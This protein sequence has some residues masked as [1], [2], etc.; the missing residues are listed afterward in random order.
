MVSAVSLAAVSVSWATQAA[1]PPVTGSAISTGIS[2]LSDGSSIVTGYFFGTATFG[3]TTLTATSATSDLFVAKLDAAG[4]YAWATSV[5]GFSLDQGYAISTLSD[6]SSIVTG[7]FYETVAFGS[8][9]PITSTGNQDVFVAKLDASGNWLWATKAGGS[10]DEQGRAVSTLSDGSSIV[11]GYFYGTAAFGSTSLESAGD[12]D[13]FVAKIDASGNWLWATKAG[14][15]PADV[16]RGISTISDG[17]AIVTGKIEGDATFGSTTL[18]NAGG[19]D[20]FVAKIDASGNWLWATK[21]GGSSGEEGNAISTLSDG[22]S[23][24]TGYFYGTATFG[25]ITL[26]SADSADLFVTKIDPSGN[27]VWAT[28]AGNTYFD[29]STA[30]STL[31]DGSAIVT[32]LFIG[33]STFGATTFEV[34]GNNEF[35]QDIFVAR[36]DAGG[37]WKWAR[38]EGGTSLD[39]GSAVSTLSDGSA[40]VTGNFRG[41]AIIG[42]ITLEYPDSGAWNV[43]VAKFTPLDSDNDGVSDEQEEINGTDPTKADTDDDGENDGAEGT[44]DSDNDGT[45]DALESSVTD[46]DNDGVPDEQDSNNTSGDNDTDGDGVSNADEV[47]AGTDPMDSD[48]IPVTT[49]PTFALLLLSLLLSLFGYRRMAH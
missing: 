11:T 4:N 5:G 37:D 47:A 26:T 9:P 19:P 6:G 25:S 17:S 35:A 48:S 28:R 46:T 10:L 14:G 21:A 42:D 22:S 12:A 43:V 1:A 33:T 7:Y 29:V 18:T 31:S 49:L 8:T 39:E 34:A 20:V 13:V 3:S 27:F 41:N 2:T 40:I 32:G 23:I 30:I 16:G 24:V 36:I 44:T 45:I 38:R 15:G